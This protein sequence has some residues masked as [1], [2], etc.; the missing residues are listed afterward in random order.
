MDP[1]RSRE[2]NRALLAMYASGSADRL[3]LPEPLPELLSPLRMEL[4]GLPPLLVQA[5]DGEVLLSDAVRLA[6]RARAAGVRVELE[7]WERMRSV[8]QAL[9]PLLPEARRAIGR[10]GGFVRECLANPAI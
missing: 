1:T 6:E 7:V 10:I 2:I 9:A 3:R 8:F 4:A 5:G